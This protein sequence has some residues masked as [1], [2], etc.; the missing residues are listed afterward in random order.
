MIKNADIA[1]ILVNYNG[2]KDTFECLRSLEESSIPLQAI[3]I[4]N[5]S[6]EN[7]AFLISKSFPN[8]HVIRSE[9]NLG[10]SGGNNLGIKWALDC[11]YKYIALLN[12][13]TIVQRNTFEL[14]KTVTDTNTVALPIIYYHSIPTDVWFGGGYINKFTGNALHK[15]RSCNMN[16]VNGCCFMACREIWIK[17]GFLDESYFMYN[18]DTDFSIRLQNN[19]VRISLVPKAV[20]YHKVGMSSGGV[21]SPLNIY[22]VTRNRIRVI[23]KHLGYFHWTALPFTIVTRLMWM[24][25]YFLQ[26]KKEWKY[27]YQGVRDGMK[28]IEGKVEL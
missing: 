8:V 26:G 16:F 4:D 28:G 1:I 19:E 13:D 9:E 18:E 20:I 10:F 7:E 12:N 2:L 24:A 11:G 14:L 3:V 5:A 22:Y 25:K 17:V 27:F 6:K 23:R 21:L 15:E